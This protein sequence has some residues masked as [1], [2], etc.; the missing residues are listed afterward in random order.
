MNTEKQFRID[1]GDNDL[2]VTT[3]PDLRFMDV[4]DSAAIHAL[5]VGESHTDRDGDTWE[6]IA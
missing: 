5:Q 3:N 1:Y 4:G 2:D 6:R